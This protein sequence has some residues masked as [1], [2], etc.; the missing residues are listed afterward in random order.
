MGSGWG[1]KFTFGYEECDLSVRLTATMWVGCWIGLWS[2]KENCGLHIWPLAKNRWH[3]KLEGTQLAQLFHI[4]AQ[5]FKRR[6]F[7]CTFKWSI[8]PPV[9]YTGH[10][11]VLLYSYPTLL[12]CEACSLVSFWRVRIV[13]F[14]VQWCMFLALSLF[15]ESDKR[16]NDFWYRKCNVL[17]KV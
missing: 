11:S 9:V 16:M 4:V 2:S 6:D 8:W 1:W 10:R 14:M 12:T 7:C 5:C 3:L 17:K 13:N 15:S